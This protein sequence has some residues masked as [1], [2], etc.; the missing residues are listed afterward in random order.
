MKTDQWTDDTFFNLKQELYDLSI[1]EISYLTTLDIKD[2]PKL[3][4][5]EKFMHIHMFP[6]T[7]LNFSGCQ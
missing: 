3:Y 7:N 5:T 1:K 6:F 4:F 2:F